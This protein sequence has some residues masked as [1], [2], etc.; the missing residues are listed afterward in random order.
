MDDID[1][2]RE[3]IAWLPSVF[4]AV[5]IFSNNQKRLVPDCIEEYPNAG[6]ADFL[7][8]LVGF[9]TNEVEKSQINKW[10]R[11]F[12]NI[13]EQPSRVLRYWMHNLTFD[14]QDIKDH[15]R[16]FRHSEETANLFLKLLTT[17][18]N[19]VRSLDLSEVVFSQ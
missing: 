7:V 12:F 14:I 19:T 18:F 11:A 5:D 15:R 10:L 17:V 8:Y 9:M 4:T 2:P 13:L 3:K 6:M 1:V 16:L